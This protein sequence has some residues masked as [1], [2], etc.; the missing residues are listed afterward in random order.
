MKVQI[1]LRASDSTKKR[2]RSPA[3]AKAHQFVGTGSE[4]LAFGH[5]SFSH[6][7][8]FFAAALVQVVLG[9]IIL[10]FD[11]SFTN[12]QTNRPETTFPRGKHRHRPLPTHSHVPVEA[13][14]KAQPRG[15]HY[16][17]FKPWKL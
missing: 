13:V 5:G 2:S 4:N 12:G 7:G 14:L 8:R 6:P 9:E 11:L 15:C 3:E 10:T 1:S 17:H 16:I